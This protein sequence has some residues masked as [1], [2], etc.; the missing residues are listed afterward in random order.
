MKYESLTKTALETNC[1]KFH[2]KILSFFSEKLPFSSWDFLAAPCSLVDT[3][4]H[5]NTTATIRYTDK[6]RNNLLSNY[7]I[8][9]VWL[10]TTSTLSAGRQGPCRGLVGRLTGFLSVSLKKNARLLGR[11]GSGPRLVADRADVVFTHTRIISAKINY[12]I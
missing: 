2:N 6:H 11:L 12:L 7:T 9:S 8:I 1:R 10:N 3:D 5:T 4:R